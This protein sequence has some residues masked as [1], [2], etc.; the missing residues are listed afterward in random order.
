MHYY[1]LKLCKIF[2]IIKGYCIFQFLFLFLVCLFVCLFACLLFLFVFPFADC[3]THS[4]TSMAGKPRLITQEYFQYVS[5]YVCEHLMV[6]ISRCYLILSIL[7]PGPLTSPSYAS[8]AVPAELLPAPYYTQAQLSLLP[9]YTN[10][11]I[12]S[13]ICFF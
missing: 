4:M 7:H 9:T 11:G 8:L 13:Y 5:M 10:S 1:Y 3:L 12:Y 2:I 6:R